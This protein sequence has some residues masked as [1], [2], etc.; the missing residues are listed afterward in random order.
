MKDLLAL[1]KLAPEYKDLILSVVF[2]LGT[3]KVI[4]DLLRQ[5][6]PVIKDFTNL[7]NRNT[8]RLKLL[9]SDSNISPLSQNEF[10]RRYEL[11]FLRREYGIRSESFYPHIFKIRQSKPDLN[12]DDFKFIE[13]FLT[14][15]EKKLSINIRLIDTAEYISN[16]CIY[17]A[18]AGISMFTIFTGI[19]QKL[20]AVE[21]LISMSFGILIAM[22][23]MAVF[24][25]GFRRY[26]IAK[27]YKSEL[28][29]YYKEQNSKQ[30]HI[31][32]NIDIHLK[33]E[34][35]EIKINKNV[36]TPA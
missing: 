23:I 24:P 9:I 8:D 10:R 6:I 31:S 14:V 19:L 33:E 7:S 35:T 32:D 12:I 28:E 26:R 29:D 21:S 4:T 15:R 34:Y 30:P 1:F 11:V 27:Y 25:K 36:Q 16:M 3:L 20:E 2:I 22:V 17:F 13:N 5:L 18:L